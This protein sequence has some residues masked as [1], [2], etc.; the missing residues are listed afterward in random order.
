MYFTRSSEIVLLP[1][2]NIVPNLRQPR[3]FFDRQELESLSQSILENGLL[4]PITVRPLKNNDFEI[5]AG[6]RRFRACVIAGINRIPSVII[7][8]SAERAAILSLS[9]KIQRQNLNFFEEAQ[10]IDSLIKTY[11][12]TV[13]YV[14][15]LLGKPPSSISDLL[16]LLSLP[17]KIRDTIIQNNLTQHHAQALLRLSDEKEIKCVLEKIV[18]N[19]L[20]ATQTEDLI[21]KLFNEKNGKSVRKTRMFFKDLKIF[22]NTLDHAVLTMNQS[23]IQAQKEHFENDSFIRYTVTIPKT[24]HKI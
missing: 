19:N 23:G 12:Y 5:V 15:S 14:S 8:S 2:E 1:V 22:V 7:E 20:S 18:L 13:E 17:Q 9:D 6:E 11:S 16:R 24:I 3:K 21:D 10:A 4:Q